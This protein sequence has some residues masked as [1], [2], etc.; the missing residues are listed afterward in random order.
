MDLVLQ[1]AT[2]LTQW[3]DCHKKGFIGTSDT[4]RS[5]L[6]IQPHLAKQG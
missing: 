3:T 2:S 1:I 4:K 6:W 5:T